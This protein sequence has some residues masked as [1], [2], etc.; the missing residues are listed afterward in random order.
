MAL[1]KSMVQRRMGRLWME[2]AIVTVKRGIHPMK[3]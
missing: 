1:I 3:L 2:F